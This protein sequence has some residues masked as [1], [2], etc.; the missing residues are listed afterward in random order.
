M[1]AEVSVDLGDSLCPLH[2]ENIK[3]SRVHCEPV[4]FV[5]ETLRDVR[6]GVFPSFAVCTYPEHTSVSQTS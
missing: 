4:L 3:R 5:L 1:S 6:F 2:L